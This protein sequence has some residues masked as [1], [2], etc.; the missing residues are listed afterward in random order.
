MSYTEEQL[1]FI[2]YKDN[3]SIILSATAGSGKTHS[4]VGRLNQLI[5]DGVDP[6]RIIFFSF[7]NDAVNELKSRITHDVEV[8]TIH[9][10]TARILGK[11]G[12]FKNIITFYDFVSWY[13]EINKP[14]PKDPNTIK[15]AYYQTLELF[16]EEGTQI[17]SLFSAYK[18][19][20]SDGIK[21]PKPKYY[22]DYEKFLR[23]SRS[24]DFSDMLIDTEKLSRD[25][26]YKDFFEG[27]Y[28]HV[29][30]DEYQDTSSLQLKILLR[31]KAQQYY[32]IGDENQS[33][34]SFSGA[35]CELIEDLLTKERTTIRLTLSKNFRSDKNIVEH[36][37]KFS[38]IKAIPHSEKEGDVHHRLINTTDFLLMVNDP[39][40][41]TVLA[42]SNK[43]IKE[44]EKFCLIKKLPIKYFNFITPTDIEHIKKNEI[45]G[46]IKL[47]LDKVR[48]YFGSNDKLIEFIESNNNSD[49]FITS[50]HKSKGREFPR[51][52]VVNS[53]DPELAKKHNLG[54]EYTYETKD[55]DVNQEEKNI[56][57]VA[58]TRPKHEVYFMVFN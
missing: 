19:Q 7:T 52:I 21:L 30:I 2:E 22:V 45:N 12:K 36:A 14:N 10:Y 58:V 53:V 1:K 51:V 32:L 23:E 37:N 8:T 44:L 47:R 34:Y 40:P 20:T 55:G 35:N 5:S 4:C 43:T 17:S 39:N 25:E 57:Y 28:D 41:L 16:Y 26:K 56:H 38:K 49:K 6:K 48:P 54:K 27:T 3:E 42:R 29:F 46:S 33:I 31:I 15:D 50:I 13:K 11:M 9:S 18:L 24:R